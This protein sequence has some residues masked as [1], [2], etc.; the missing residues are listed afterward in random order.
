MK[1][2]HRI[3][4]GFFSWP[5]P[6]RIRQESHRIG[7]TRTHL[8]E[9]H[10]QDCTIAA[11]NSKDSTHALQQIRPYRLV[12]FRALPGHDDLRRRRRHLGADRRPA[13]GRGRAPDRPLARCRN[14][15]HRHRR[16]LCRRPLGGHHRPGAAKPEGPARERGRRHEGVR[17]DRHEERQFARHVTPS[18][19][20]R[21]EGEPE[22]AAAGPHR[23]V[24]DPWLRSG[25]TDRGDRAR[26]RQ[27]GAARPR[28]LRRR[29]ELGRLA[30]HEGARHLRNGWVW[31]DSSRCRPTTRSPAAISSAN[32]FRC[33]RAKASA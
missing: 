10:S 31:R 17:R 28:A 11:P 7:L 15:F 16:R 25:N 26:A 33:S 3:D 13:A 2:R 8:P 4:G 22:A 14:Q 27:P 32:W 19:H 24:P 23:P 6:S 30:D 5:E 9:G 18:H 29:V 12:R 1:T 21:R 20:G